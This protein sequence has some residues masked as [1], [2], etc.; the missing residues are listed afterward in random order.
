MDIVLCIILY[1]KQTRNVGCNVLRLVL[2]LSIIGPK[3][4]VSGIDCPKYTLSRI[5]YKH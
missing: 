2:P 4:N 5:E 3:Y 1:D